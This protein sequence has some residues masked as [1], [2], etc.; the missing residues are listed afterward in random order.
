MKLDTNDFVELEQALSAWDQRYE[1]VSPGDFHGGVDLVGDDTLGVMR[2]RWGRRIHYQGIPPD[3][4]VAFG[5]TFEQ[6]GEGH[7]AGHEVR[8]ETLLMQPR[9]VEAEYFSAPM[10]DSLVVTVRE[11][12]LVERVARFTEADPPAAI[13]RPAA[14]GLRTEITTRIARLGLA[15]IQAA[16]RHLEDPSSDEV[17]SHQLREALLDEVGFAVACAHPIQSGQPSLDRQRSLVARAFDYAG[18]HGSRPIRFGEMCR[19][20]HVSP[21][22]MRYAFRSVTGLPPTSALKA[23]RLNDA[24]RGLR[25]AKASTTLVKQVALDHGFRHLG[26]FSQDYRALFG[27]SPSET[28]QRPLRAS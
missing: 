13:Q 25:T 18:R 26:Y 9:G 10:W 3:G 16:D 21:R 27:E 8:P 23:K 22:T 7:W 19:D 12:E 2:L 5:V 15:Y 11:P 28:L 1:Q 20:L 6:V 17:S 24:Y 14:F 4:A